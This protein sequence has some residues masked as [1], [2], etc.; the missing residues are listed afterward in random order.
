MTE[1]PLT[2][3]EYLIV[4]ILVVHHLSYKSQGPKLME[5][6]S[7]WNVLFIIFGGLVALIWLLKKVNWWLHE[8]KLGVKQYSLPPGDL[9]WPFIGNMWSFLHAFKSND[10]DSFISNFVT[11][12]H[13]PPLSLFL[14][15]LILSYINIYTFF[16]HQAKIKF[17]ICSY[18]FI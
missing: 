16:D 9:G 11:R 17:S 13:T 5:L 8:T 2:L 12:S 4:Q 6:G 7:I 1:S 18:W 14:S 15:L 10:P 3:W